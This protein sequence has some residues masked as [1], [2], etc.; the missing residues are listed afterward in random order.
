ME[1]TKHQRGNES[2]V[3][4]F[5][6][7][8]KQICYIMTWNLQSYDRLTTELRKLRLSYE[9]RFGPSK[10]GGKV[11]IDLRKPFWPLQKT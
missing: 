11:T 7:A 1:R 9:N 10:N 8:A 2:G 4:F 6:G 3:L 5:D